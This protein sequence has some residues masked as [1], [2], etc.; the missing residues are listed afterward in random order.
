MKNLVALLVAVATIAPVSAQNAGPMQIEKNRPRQTAVPAAKPIVLHTGR[1]ITPDQKREVQVSAARSYAA[2]FPG[3]KLRAN[4]ESGSAPAISTVT[5][6]PLSLYQT[7]Y[8]DTEWNNAPYVNPELNQ[9]TFGPGESSYIDFIFVAA[10]N[11]S[12]TMTFK[13][14]AF[15]ANPQYTILPSLPPGNGP[16]GSETFAGNTGNDEFSFA[17]VADKSGILIVSLY[18]PNAY[19]T[20]GSCE[21]TAIPIS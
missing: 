14:N 12:Y 8:I 5:L 11:T 10:A 16:N 18:S 6:T 19:W 20:F 13:V 15:T 21:I 7:G 9:I 17:F 2:K 3:V 1:P 4:V